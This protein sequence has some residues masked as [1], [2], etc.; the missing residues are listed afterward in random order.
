MNEPENYMYA[1]EYKVF[2]KL[3][4][5]T[6]F[7]TS[8][9]NE[10]IYADKIVFL[11]PFG[12]SKTYNPACMCYGVEAVALSLPIEKIMKNLARENDHFSFY[13]YLMTNDPK[14]D[15]YKPGFIVQGHVKRT[16]HEILNA[17]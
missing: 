3:H 10:V 13:V 9:V 17:K 4:Q 11:D 1:A 15:C 7:L 5:R 16:M 12:K 6:T 14:I 8:Y 2:V